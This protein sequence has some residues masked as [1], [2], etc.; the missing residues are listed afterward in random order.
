[1]KSLFTFL[2]FITAVT[3]ANAQTT[4][5]TPQFIDAKYSKG[6]DAFSQQ[7]QTLVQHYLS[8]V[9]IKYIDDK[10]AITAEVS[11]KGVVE[12]FKLDPNFNDDMQRSIIRELM[13]LPRLTP[14]TLDGKPV[15][16]KFTI[17]FNFHLGV[18]DFLIN[19][20][21]DDELTK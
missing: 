1:M 15:K 5:T 19:I 9:D 20:N 13:K 16:E 21:R 10:M 7:T 6:W 11:E 14:A 2:V 12:N 18:Y 4:A 8:Q 17:T 3:F